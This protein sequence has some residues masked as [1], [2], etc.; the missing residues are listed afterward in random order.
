MRSSLLRSAAKAEPGKTIQRKTKI[1][2]TV[3]LAIFNPSPIFFLP[4]FKQQDA[5]GAR[6]GEMEK[7]IKL[8]LEVQRSSFLSLDGGST[9]LTTLS[10]SK[11]R[12]LR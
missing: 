7:L 10:L 6:P 2:A 1:A 9:G 12:G 11:W 3:L 5:V 4:W 8:S